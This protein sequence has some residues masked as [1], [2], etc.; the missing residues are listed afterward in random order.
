MAEL[1]QEMGIALLLI[2]HDLRSGAEIA[3]QVAL[4]YAEESVEIT[5]A[6]ELY[7]PPATPHPGAGR[8][9]AFAPAVG[10]HPL[11]QS[12]Q[13]KMTLPL[14]PERITAKASSNSV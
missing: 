13:F 8:Q 3:N 14:C 6:A 10:N 2:T 9:P 4:M 1:Q 11:F 5:P 7:Q 12:T